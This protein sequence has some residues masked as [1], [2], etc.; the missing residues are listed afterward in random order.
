MHSAFRVSHFPK[1][2]VRR[3]AQQTI[4]T[5]IRF[6][7]RL[8]PVT[9]ER[10]YPLR[11]I[12]RSKP[13]IFFS[14]NPATDQLCF[15]WLES[16]KAVNRHS[17]YPTTSMPMERAVPRTLLIA[18]STLAAFKSGIFCFAISSTCFAVTLP[19]LSLFG[20]PDPLAIPAARFSNTEAGGVLVINVKERSL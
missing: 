2:P 11:R 17:N 13:L 18:E 14:A 19:T 10:H 16:H 12:I 8:K 6:G 1:A 9:E 20:V 5:T 15:M 3:V 7:Y 4:P